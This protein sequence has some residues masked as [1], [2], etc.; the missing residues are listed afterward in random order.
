MIAAQNGRS[1]TESTGG[2]VRMG[3]SFSPTPSSRRRALHRGT[4][5]GYSQI[6]AA[7]ITERRE[8]EAKYRGLLEAAPDAMV[9]DKPGAERS[10]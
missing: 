10:S 1:E 8:T 7:D 3:R 5:L 2:C 9:S 6:T 4:L